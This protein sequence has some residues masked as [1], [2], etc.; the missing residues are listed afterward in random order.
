MRQAVDLNRIIPIF[1][2]EDQ[3]LILKDGRVAIG[4]QV[5]PMEMECWNEA[6]Y[7]SFNQSFA[8]ALNVLPVGTVIQKSDIFYTKHYDQKDHNDRYFENKQRDHFLGRP[9]LFHRSYLFLSFPGNKP[10][11]SN[12]VNTIFASEKAILPNPFVD[13]EQRMELAETQANEFISGLGKDEIQFDRLSDRQLKVLCK[14]YLNLEFDCEPD[15]RALYNHLQ[16]LLIG[17]KMINVLSLRGQGVTSFPAVRNHYGIPAPMAYPLT[18]PLDFPH[19]LTQNMLIEDNEKELSRL[20][21]DK[22]LNNS[23]DFLSTQDN[24]IKS[25]EIDAFTEEVRSQNKKLV[26]LN[27]SVTLWAMNNRE[28]KAGIEKTMAAFRSMFGCETIVESYDTG[29]LFFAGIPGNAAQNYRWLLTS[30]DRAVNYFHYTTSY[31]DELK[32][33]ILCDRFQK[34]V[35]INLFN[36]RLNNQNAIVIGPSGSGKSYTIGSLIVQRFERGCRQV[37]IDIG[38][39]YRNVMLSL[40]GKL[41][42]ETYFVYSAEK[43]LAF[44]PFLL[45]ME[46]GQYQIHGDKINFLVGLISIIWKGSKQVLSSAERSVLVRLIPQYYQNLNQEGRKPGLTDFYEWLKGYHESRKSDEEYLSTLQFFNLPQLLIVLKPFVDGEYKQVLNAN[47]EIDISEHKLVCFDM[48]RIK[49][50]PVLYPVVSMLITELALDQI[51][52]FPEDIK[53]IYMDE[54]WAMLSDAMGDW[55]ESMFRTIRKNNG[56]MCIITQGI[57]EIS[58]SKVGAAI[59]NNAQTKII[60]YHSDQQQVEGLASLLGFT[61]HELDKIRSM[62]VGTGYRELFI[63]QAEVGKVFILEASPHLDAVLSSK[64]AERNYL[65]KLIAKYQKIEYA[66]NQY[67]EDKNSGKINA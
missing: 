53:Y 54:A 9:L 41:F 8:A 28:R 66:V 44:N 2:V 7:T 34:P 31:K 20:D 67:I 58:T 36:T 55:V 49:A 5:H 22:K 16:G 27:L 10:L 24:R 51:R 19:I 65:Q 33:D 40:N 12:P 18:F 52:K 64:P 62:R 23:L 46:N 39:S 4:Y 48:D 17:E 1:S 26:S 32:G 11:K 47:Y 25:E 35:K 61:R 29:N 15:F 42:D 57:D 37:I 50:D 43:P 21:F 59:I 38:G 63:K 13:I 56:S 60:L 30:A 3:Q 45:S 6:Q 14:Q